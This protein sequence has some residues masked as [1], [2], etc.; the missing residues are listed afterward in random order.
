MEKEG[1]GKTRKKRD[2]Q[3]YKGEGKREVEEPNK[4]V[5][6]GKEKEK[7]VARKEREIRLG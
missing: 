4:Q 5:K 3:G 2:K 6:R 1:R 7:G